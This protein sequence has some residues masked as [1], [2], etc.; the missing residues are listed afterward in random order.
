MFKEFKEFAMQGNVMDLAIGIVIGAAFG[1]I[2]TSFVNDVLMPPIGLL[3]GKVDFADLY[4]NLSST[5]YPSLA[6]AREA[7]APVIAY[8]MFLNNIIDFLI[9]AIAI[10]FVV[11][12]INKLKKEA[13]E[14]VT[15]KE[16][17]YC[18]SEIPLLATRCPQC[19]SELETK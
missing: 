9:V 6:L 1:K 4:L 19:T 3:M 8:G 13:V 16:C 14:E 7:G 11:R 5:A 2:V 10:F 12:L 15:T 17:G 18:F